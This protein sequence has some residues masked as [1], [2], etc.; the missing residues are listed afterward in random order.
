MGVVKS[1][2]SMVTRDGQMVLSF[3]SL[4]ILAGCDK[5]DSIIINNNKKIFFFTEIVFAILSDY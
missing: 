4:I 3:M 2:G 5:P 1:G